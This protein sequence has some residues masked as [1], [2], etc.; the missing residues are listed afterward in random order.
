[1]EAGGYGFEQAMETTVKESVAAFLLSLV[2]VGCSSPDGSSLKSEAGCQ[3]NK[4]PVSPV[5]PPETTARN[6]GNPKGGKMERPN[7]KLLNLIFKAMDH[8]VDSVINTNGPLFPFAMIEDGKGEVT[9]ARF[10]TGKNA[11]EARQ[12][13]RAFVAAEV[14]CVRYAVAADGNATENGQRIPAVM[15]EAGQRGEPNGFCMIQ[16]F[17]SSPN[18]R[19]AKTVRNP[20]IIAFP[21]VLDNKKEQQ[22]KEL[23]VL[24]KEANNAQSSAGAQL[25]AGAIQANEVEYWASLG[26]IGKV[27]LALQN[28]ADVNAK[29]EGGYTALHAAAENG[30]MEIVAILLELGADPHAKMTTGQ[31]PLDLAKQQKHQAIVDLLEKR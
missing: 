14:N 20:G 17:E 5:T 25:P 11:D 28:G 27:K 24:L 12:H 7:E 2:M 23:M 3:S 18:C 21:D 13:A 30:H 8:G 31:T 15:V 26:N 19:Y 16:R 6:N 4:E 22:D 10:T 9:L 29:G 1:V